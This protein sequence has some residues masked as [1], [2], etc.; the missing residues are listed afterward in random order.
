[1]SLSATQARGAVLAVA[2]RAVLAVLVAVGSQVRAQVRVL[3]DRHGKATTA[4]L[5]LLLA[6]G[7]VAQARP[8]TR[9][10]LV[11][12]ATAH[13]ISASQKQQFFTQAAVG[14]ATTTPARRIL[15]AREAAVTAALLLTAMLVCRTV[16]VG[17][18]AAIRHLL[19]KSQAQAQRGWF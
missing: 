7:V 1:V 14:L 3:L 8:V 12:A 9:M 13:G 15:A 18:A 19:P 17:A 10:G 4:A 5:T 11:T 16:A 2:V 6:V